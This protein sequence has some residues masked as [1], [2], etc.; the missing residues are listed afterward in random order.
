MTQP[1]PP[2]AHPPAPPPAG[3]V[4]RWVWVLPML[5]FAALVAVAAGLLDRA[6]GESVAHAIIFGGTAF[7]GTVVLLLGLAHFVGGGRG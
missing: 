4:P 3:G 7:A 5:L 6:D 2:V 1:V